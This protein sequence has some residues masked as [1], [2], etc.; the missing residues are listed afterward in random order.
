MVI[1]ERDKGHKGGARAPR[2]AC[3]CCASSLVKHIRS[4]P[5]ERFVGTRGYYADGRC[6]LALNIDFEIEK[7]KLCNTRSSEILICSHLSPNSRFSFGKYTRMK[8]M[9]PVSQI[10]GKTAL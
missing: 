8:H 2:V 6:G 5:S 9:H 3:C 4:D 1:G 10:F 7:K